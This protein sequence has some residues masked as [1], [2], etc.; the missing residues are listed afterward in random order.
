M[1]RP[2]P[3]KADPTK[4]A[5]LRRKFL[6]DVTRH[7]RKIAKAIYQKINTEDSFGLKPRY[8]ILQEMNSLTINLEWAALSSSEQASAFRDWLA[9]EVT[10]DILAAAVTTEEAWWTTYIQQ[11]YEKG[12]GRSYDDMLASGYI[13][14]TQDIGPDFYLGTKESFLRSSFLQPVHAEKIKLLAERVLNELEGVTASMAQVITR[15]LIDGLIAGNS[16]LEIADAL[17]EKLGLS[18]RRAETIARTEI[19]RA[20]A[21]G[22][23]D[24]LERLGAKKLRVMVEWS[25]AGD[26]R[27]CPLC[28]DKDGQVIPIDE[29]RGVIPLHPNCRCAWIPANVGE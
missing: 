24:A 18:A 1:S 28:A 13:T 6:A 16:P 4:T 12:M 5:T 17:V 10:I 29:A 7:F 25:A 14:S 23:L 26:D 22:Q 15:E 21:E 3:L 11:A 20:H 8:F 2:N 27:T 19:I 9:T